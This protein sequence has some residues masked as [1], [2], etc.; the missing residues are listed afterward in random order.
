[1]PIEFLCKCGEN[2][3][4]LDSAVGT[5][6]ACPVCKAVIHVSLSAFKPGGSGGSDSLRVAGGDDDTG[7]PKPAAKPGRQY[8]NSLEMGR[9]TIVTLISLGVASVLGFVFFIIYQDHEKFLLPAPSRARPVFKKDAFASAASA[10]SATATPPPASSSV[11]PSPAEK[12]AAMA[13]QS[14]PQ[15]ETGLGPA[16]DIVKSPAPPVEPKSMTFDEIVAKLEPSVAVIRG[17]ESQG[18]GFVIAPGRVVT[19][20]HLI[21]RSLPITIK[22]SFP[23]APLAQQGPFAA[24]VLYFDDDRN[25]AILEVVATTSPIPVATD[26][27]FRR[28]EDVVYI[29]GPRV[30]DRSPRGVVA[31]G[32]LGGEARI[33]DRDYYEL[34]GPKTSTLSGAPVIDSQGRVVALLSTRG[35]GEAMGLC[36]PAS[37]MNKAIGSLKEPAQVADAKRRHEISVRLSSTVVRNGS[38][39]S[40]DG[41]GDKN[42]LNFLG[43]TEPATWLASVDS[44]V[45][46]ANSNPSVGPIRDRLKRV[47]G[48]YAEGEK[49]IAVS[50]IQVVGKIRDAGLAASCESFLDAAAKWAPE[51]VLKASR[52]RS[53][54]AFGDAYADLRVVDRLGHSEALT[55]MQEDPTSLPPAL[56]GAAPGPAK[57]QGADLA[58]AKLDLAMKLEYE[59]KTEAAI[60]A[61]QAV[62]DNFPRTPQSGIAQ[63]RIKI[64]TPKTP[65]AAA[66][67]SGKTVPRG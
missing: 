5:S 10:A 20:A 34:N 13:R 49:T 42:L 9:S 22:V 41:R 43:A 32:V 25:L 52:K 50:A 62:V 59:G 65:P 45:Y 31:S 12:A 30:N 7:K 2:L 6:G 23:A 28:G 60:A 54:V 24:E 29:G 33:D 1:M 17:F 58:T 26:Y 39:T 67:N 8:V 21:R 16:P 35:P 38:P 47:K 64:L 44:S 51:S 36:L 55:R 48:Y 15:P 3:H 11:Q 40:V 37:A 4:I 53:I 27:V 18:A 63:A 57:G 14:V 19:N 66:P 61:F 56:T 46:L